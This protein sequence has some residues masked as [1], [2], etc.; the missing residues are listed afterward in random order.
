MAGPEVT[1]TENFSP[2]NF[3]CLD[4]DLVP[5]ELRPMDRT[6]SVPASS[7][8]TDRFF[9]PLQIISVSNR[10]H[11]SIDSTPS[12]VSATCL[13]ASRGRGP[14]KIDLA[15]RATASTQHQAQA[16]LVTAV[17]TL[18]AREA[19]SPGAAT[20][21][22]NQLISDTRTRYFHTGKERVW[23]ANPLLSVWFLRLIFFPPG[24]RA[25]LCLSTQGVKRCKERIRGCI[26]DLASGRALAPQAP[27]ASCL[28]RRTA[29]HGTPF[30]D[31]LATACEVA[32]AGRVSAGPEE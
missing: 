10:Y 26:A 5:T 9:R 32:A 24:R 22:R 8:A 14:E 30:T 3:G 13:P 16:G 7:I 2:S 20:G 23:S 28:R 11:Q 1:Y 21:L 29:L 19:S 31:R 12:L 17:A 15:R 6:R 27:Q 4:A 18:P 25:G